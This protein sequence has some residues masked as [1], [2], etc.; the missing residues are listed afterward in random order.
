[1]RL[2]HYDYTSAGIYF[3]TICT[4][5]RA[6]FFDQPAVRAAAGDCWQAIPA[7]I[8][9]VTLDEWV[10]MPNH[11]HGLLVFASAGQP[12]ASQQPRANSLGAVVRSYK[13]AVART[14]RQA[15]YSRFAWQRGYYEHVVRLEADLERI[16]A[17]IR[18]NPAQWKLDHD[19]PAYRGPAPGPTPWND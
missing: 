11:L 7:H 6:L 12:P 10:L 3:V 13:A 19:N 1:M 8:A 14:V 5:Q 17:Y 18:N 4:H 15:G 16:R 2:P 9:G